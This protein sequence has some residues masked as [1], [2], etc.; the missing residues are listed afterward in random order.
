[1][2]KKHRKNTY[3]PPSS[4]PN[5]E[6]LKFSFEYYDRS[7]NDYCLSCWSQTQ[8]KETLSRLQEV[9]TKTFNK[10]MQERR[11]YHFN[12]VIWEKTIKKKGFPNNEINKLSPFHFALIGVNG[13]LARIY[14]AYST[15]TFFIV[16]FDLN[17]KIWPTKLKHT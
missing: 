9:C 15:G 3:I 14:G 12:E 6:K 1:M 5:N 10:L 2:G 4:L 13:Q 17:H 16:W 11:V 8:I 7:S